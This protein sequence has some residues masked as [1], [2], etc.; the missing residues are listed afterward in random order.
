MRA[1]SLRSKGSIWWAWG[2]L[3][4]VLLLAAILRLWRLHVLPPGL[5]FD[6]AVNGVDA[7][8]VLAGAGLPLYFSANNG[9]EP[10]FIYLQTLSV[11]LLGVK[12]YALR[13][14]SAFCGILTIPAVYFC[15]RTILRPSV[16]SRSADGSRHNL[17]IWA[18]LLAAAIVAVSFWHLSLSRL[19]LRAV[20]LPPI[21]ALAMAFFW[22]GWIH[23]QRRGYLWAGFFL[24]L[25]F[26][27]Y[28]AARLLP[29]VLLGFVL[30]DAC[31]D[32][33]RTRRLPGDDRLALRQRWRSRLNGLASLAFVGLF[34][35]VPLGVAAVRDP[36]VALGRSSGLS[37]FAAAVWHGQ[38]AGALWKPL[39]NN[40]WLVA[41]SFYDLGQRDLRFNLPGRPINDPLL[42]VLFTV[43][44]LTALW[45]IKEPRY[46]LLLIW[47]AVM[48]LPTVLSPDAPHNL[49][50]VGALPPM[51]LLCAAGGDAIV[52][53]LRPR[54]RQY[55]AFAL[56]VAVVVVS[57][58]LT[59]HDY[60]GVWAS[61]AGLGE[62]F[63]VRQA[64]AGEAVAG[65]LSGASGVQ[66][67]VM[68]HSLYQEPQVAFA[69]GPISYRDE[70]PSWSTEKNS[71]ALNAVFGN[72][73]GLDEPLY[74]LWRDTGGV[75]A[76]PLEPLAPADV[77][78][79]GKV[80]G[81]GAE[82][83]A[84]LDPG[85]W[86]K[87]VTSLVPAGIRLQPRV[88]PNPLDV[89]FANGLRLVGYDVQAEGPGSD[90]KPLA[91]RL[92]SFWRSDAQTKSGAAADVDTFVHLADR[93]GVWNTL[94]GILSENHLLAWP[95]ANRMV[96][97]VRVLK[98]PPEMPAGKAHFEVG[99]YRRFLQPGSTEYERVP[100]VDPQGRVAGDR[101]DLG[102]VMVGEPPPQA[103]LSGLEPLGARFEDHIELAGWNART[104]P[105]DPSL[106]FVDLGWRA[107]A[108][109][110]TDYT[111]FVHLLDQ[112]GGIASQHD[113]P[114]GGPENPTALWVPGEVVRTTFSLRLP[115]G[116]E[117]RSHTLRVG[118]YEPVS[119]RRLAVMQPGEGAA[120]A[121]GQTFLLL[122]TDR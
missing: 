60:F 5:L 47:L 44:W 32:L 50:A 83:R 82:R 56:I 1:G 97:D 37:L 79:L 115:P 57:G 86:P 42:A 6:E 91:V 84:L 28:N 17:E 107:L 52:A 13:V 92:T 71:G 39:L 104:D 16:P 25:A 101:V 121:P 18:A 68:P 114:P 14:A 69:L 8:M 95:P 35:L 11:A 108:R 119:G 66:A 24:G 117:G 96:Q 7:R 40:A 46:R 100:I 74:L 58:G 27:T 118:L 113:Q 34:V 64:L 76:A 22:R 26:Y 112:D 15:A 55:G 59:V 38:S 29:L 111:A 85:E 122:T 51:V 4:A 2:V 20:M 110:N 102:A 49:R 105:D 116:I 48:L 9:R 30:L 106:L 73:R 19:A 65:L 103:D 10:L 90:G 80:L 89:R 72:D 61:D 78:S 81:K 77:T 31:V 88:I 41:R 120:L 63:G 62:E 3:A 12:P 70:L 21:S 33:G 87:V 53:F 43:G 75:Q 93:S 94:N 45:K 54:A 67:V 23:G 36:D 98:V 109:S 99:L